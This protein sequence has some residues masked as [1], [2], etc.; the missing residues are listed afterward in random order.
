[1]NYGEFSSQIVNLQWESPMYERSPVVVI[2]QETGKIYTIKSIGVENH[3]DSA[4]AD[5]T[6]WIKVEES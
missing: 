4:I 6:V 1:M 3:N 5:Q 2:D